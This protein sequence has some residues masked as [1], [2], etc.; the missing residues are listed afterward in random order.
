[1]MRPI[2]AAADTGCDECDAGRIPSAHGPGNDSPRHTLYRRSLSWR[3]WR[4]PHKRK[5]TEGA[6]MEEEWL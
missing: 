5:P 2:F 6:M 1:M 3:L 4:L